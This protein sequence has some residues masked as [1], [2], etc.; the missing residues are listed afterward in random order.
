[1]RDKKQGTRHKTHTVTVIEH[2]MQK[3]QVYQLVM[4]MAG[5]HFTIRSQLLTL[6]NYIS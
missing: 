5:E 3:L 1:M 6:V 4:P 2:I